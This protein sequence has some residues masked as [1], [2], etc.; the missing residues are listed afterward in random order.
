MAP[1]LWSRLKGANCVATRLVTTPHLVYGA[2]VPD[3][4]V[5]TPQNTRQGAEGAALY[6]YADV[7]EEIAFS[8]GWQRDRLAAGLLFGTRYLRPGES[9]PYIEVEG[10]VAGTHVSSLK[11]FTRVLRSE[12]KTATADLRAQFPET[13]VVGW[14]VAGKLAA[15]LDA[16]SAVLLHNTFFNHPWQTALVVT[17]GE[18]APE[19]FRPAN[20]AWS[21]VGAAVIER[22]E[23]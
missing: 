14:F 19:A 10:F 20:G 2:T 9:V 12:W 11:A 23:G 5:K 13:Q 21:D 7:L 4:L 22:A 3:A 17:T 6:V 1:G 8:G 16:P 15:E 18:E